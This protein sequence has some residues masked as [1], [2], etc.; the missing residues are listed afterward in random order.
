ML[1]DQPK[2]VFWI[3]KKNFRFCKS[4][5]NI[6]ECWW[7]LEMVIEMI[8]SIYNFFFLVCGLHLFL[9]HWLLDVFRLVVGM[10][11]CFGFEFFFR[12]CKSVEDID[13]V[14][15]ISWNVNKIINS[16]YIFNFLSS[17]WIESIF[18]SLILLKWLVLSILMC[19]GFEK[20]QIL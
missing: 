14:L 4:V 9:N 19:F 2:S 10:L 15:M 18:E 3:W 12:F 13:E 1:I 8:D 11:M 7:L 20:N 17:L 6:V 16:T 5:E